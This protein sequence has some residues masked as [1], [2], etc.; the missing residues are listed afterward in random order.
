MLVSD[1]MKS[2]A[3]EQVVFVTL[4]NAEG[5]DASAFWV[6]KWI[7]VVVCRIMNYTLT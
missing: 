3:K 7:W 6:Y 2:R 5:C 4:M 1:F